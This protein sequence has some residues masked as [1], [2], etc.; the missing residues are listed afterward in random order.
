MTDITPVLRKAR[1]SLVLAAEAVIA[2]AVAKNISSPDKSQFNRLAAICNDATCA[3]EIANYIRYQT[4][5]KNG[6]KALWEPRFAELVLEEIAGPLELLS[7]EMP[8]AAE[9]ELDTAKVEAW[10]LYAVFM[11]RAFTWAEAKKKP[12]RGVAR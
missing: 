8:N 4:G 10:R 2:K 6:R 12:A 11:T 7:L 3:E 9:S 1:K 5:R